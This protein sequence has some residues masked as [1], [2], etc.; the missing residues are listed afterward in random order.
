M[1]RAARGARLLP[2]DALK[3]IASQ[4]IVLHHLALYGPMS[5]H[6]ATLLPALFDWLATH[7]RIAVQVFLVVGGFLAG[8]RLRP[9]L[10]RPGMALLPQLIDR[11]LRLAL[12][13][14]A[15]LLMAVGAATLA[16]QWMV[17]DSIPAA[18]EPWQL[19]LHLVLLQDLVGAEALSAG[20]WYVAI[21]FQLHGLLL[22]SLALAP[23]IDAIGRGDR[24]GCSTR[25]LP[26]LMTGAVAL[27]AHWFNRDDAWDV[28]APYFLAA[29]GLGV[30]VAWR[31]LGRSA[32]LALAAAVALVLAS[33]AVEWRDRLGLA[34]A[35][36][37]GL[38]WWQA[39]G[40]RST[41]AD[42]VGS[43]KPDGWPLRSLSA[44]ARSSFSLF[45]VHFPVA[46]VVNALFVRHVPTSA[47][48]QAGGVLLAWLLSIAAG[49]CFYRR[50]ERP[51]M[52]WIDRRRV[53]PAAS[54][55]ALGVITGAPVPCIQDN[56]VAAPSHREGSPCPSSP[57]LTRPDRCRR[58]H[59]PM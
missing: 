35:V 53:A 46:L 39:R 13:L 59:R 38:W 1:S 42:A 5:D 20:V 14:A 49:E 30:L 43:V 26:W 16:R 31:S 19:L 15:A 27:S 29:Y 50:V 32:R 54:V 36:A 25:L 55:R 10:S 44:L 57:L 2:I 11:Y 21:A 41:K 40:E 58:S 23:P 9:E 33:L 56:S 3:V 28:A 4:L 18:P 37:V 52:R 6:A 51:L 47:W 34:A 24:P 8:Q 7:A 17:D 12:P 48:P 22:L 45:L